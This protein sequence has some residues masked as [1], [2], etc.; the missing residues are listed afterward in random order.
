MARIESETESD[1][2]RSAIDAESGRNSATAAIENRL[3]QSLVSGIAWTAVMRWAAQLVSWI[4]TFFA[5]R[6]LTPGDY[7]IVAMATIAVGLARMI[8][9][10]GL[11]AILVQDRTIGETRRS[12]FAGLALVVGIAMSALFVVSAGLIA[13]LFREPKVFG[14]V[15]GLG[16]L[17]TLDTLQIL[18]RA[19]LQ[20]DLS[21]DRLAIAQFVQVAVTQTV[22]ISAAL[23]GMGYMALVYNSLAGGLAVTVLLYYW[24]PFRLRWPRDLPALASPL[25]QAWRLIASRIAYYAFNSADQTLIGRVLGKDALGAYSFATTFA[26]LPLQ[27]VGPVITR[28][29]PGIFSEVQDRRAELRRYFALLSEL[30]SYLMLPISIG[31]ILTADLFVP[32]F[33]GSQWD[34]VVAPLRVLCIF[35][36][37]TATTAL[38][39]HV[40]MWTGQ[41]RANMWCTILTATVLPLGFWFT[42][43]NG[44]TA[45]AWAWAILYPLTNIPPLL[46]GLRTVRMSVR[47]WLGLLLPASASCTVMA[48]A[49]VAL[50]AALPSETS[51]LTMLAASVICG[52]AAYCAAVWFLFRDRVR[53]ILAVVK[54]RA[55]IDAALTQDSGS[56]RQ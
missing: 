39:S 10:F 21:Y 53:S 19:M 41:F 3:D 24:R 26:T 42:V 35:V 4:A 47:Q 13:E 48:L 7:G 46:I 55:V 11:D 36:A 25:R 29:V 18:P 17:C 27:E 33:L 28:V 15:V 30:L 23:A 34:A 5:A 9:D 43:D 1:E 49:V 8:D 44:L 16:L 6:L 54:R 2:A 52:V 14:A 51:V 32:L 56:L 40:M 38:I 31:M 12:E 20:R 22:L 45:V 50:R 37:S